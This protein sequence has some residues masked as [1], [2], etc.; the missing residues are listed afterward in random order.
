MQETV[1]ETITRLSKEVNAKQMIVS[2]TATA[3]ARMKDELINQQ[4]ELAMATAESHTFTVNALLRRIAELEAAQ[5]NTG[6]AT[7]AA[8]QP[9][10]SANVSDLD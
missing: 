9:A 8:K 6:A 3:I 4:G 7:P 10:N 2:K 1:Q 5:R